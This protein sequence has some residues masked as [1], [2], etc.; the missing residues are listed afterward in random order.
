[1]EAEC[2][3][4]EILAHRRIIAYLLLGTGVVS[5]FLAIYYF[6]QAKIILP[7]QDPSSGCLSL[8]SCNKSLLNDYNFYLC[9]FTGASGFASLI[10]LFQP[11]RKTYQAQIGKTEPDV[12]EEEPVE[13][14]I[15][16]EKGNEYRDV[17]RRIC[18][19]E[20]VAIQ[21]REQGYFYHIEEVA[22]YLR[23]AHKRAV[24]Y[25][26]SLHDLSTIAKIFNCEIEHPLT[27]LPTYLNAVL[28]KDNNSGPSRIVTREDADRHKFYIA[29]EIAHLIYNHEEVKLEDRYSSYATCTKFIKAESEANAFAGAL[30][31]GHRVFVNEIIKN[32]YNISE[33][34][35]V[36]SV[37]YETIAHRLVVLSPKIKFHFIKIN[38][39]K[40]ILKR[41]S[42]SGLVIDPSFK[43]IVES[44][45]AALESFKTPNR[46]TVQRTRI[47]GEIYFCFSKAFDDKEYSITVGCKDSEA[48][49][50][51][52][53]DK[54]LPIVECTP[55]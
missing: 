35:K 32:R 27:E 16:G 37:S 26:P 48:S 40:I 24:G 36:F 4:R 1:M 41:F 30:L 42:R 52:C 33:V 17:I 55:N 38:K 46:E 25:V 13:N 31:L 23:R 28:L 50:I 3:A 5:F 2:Q 18:F 49:D 12:P 39:E 9:L 20:A 43:N 54:T 47:D 7:S 21:E 10:S 8:W 34:A 22:K 15:A 45:W 53:Y 11:F 44:G 29:H 51:W 14:Q 19:S 6:L